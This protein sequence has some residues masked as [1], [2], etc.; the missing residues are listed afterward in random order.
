MR[1]RTDLEVWVH[2]LIEANCRGRANA[3][4]S[5]NL[6]CICG[7]SGPKV[8]EAIKSL[9]QEDGIAIAACI[10]GPGGYFIPL[11]SKRFTDIHGHENT[12][13]L[14]EPFSGSSAN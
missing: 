7:E 11:T 13:Y 1:V 4:T 9:I 14:D 10:A 12:S 2:C 5:R 6:G 3:M 8:R